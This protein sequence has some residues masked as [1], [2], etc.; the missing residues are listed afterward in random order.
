[1]NQSAI[2]TI[3]AIKE[4]L[5]KATKVEGF[6]LDLEIMKA[7]ILKIRRLIWLYYPEKSALFSVGKT[8][9]KE[10]NAVSNSRYNNL[11]KAKNLSFVIDNLISD[12][13]S[14]ID[15]QN[16]VNNQLQELTDR[17]SYLED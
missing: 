4:E 1:M 17:N 10:L 5:L 6:Q 12:I 14:R 3:Q 13:R 7:Y 16:P 15:Y 11:I 2:N 8:F 9:E